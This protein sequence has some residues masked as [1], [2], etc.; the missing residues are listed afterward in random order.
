MR[1]VAGLARVGRDA[2]A[3]NERKV[4]GRTT[5]MSSY[6]RTNELAYQRGMVT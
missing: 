5:K 3:A 2:Y 4:T 1:G 6:T